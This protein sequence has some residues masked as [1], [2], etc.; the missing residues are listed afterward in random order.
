M[1]ALIAAEVLAALDGRPAKVLPPELQ[2]WVASRQREAIP[3][4]LRSGARAAVERV[5]EDSELSEL[6]ARSNEVAGLAIPEE[7]PEEHARCRAA[8]DAFVDA[9][10]GLVREA[11]AHR[12]QSIEDLAQT[13][14]VD[15]AHCWPGA[16]IEA[17]A[18]KHARECRQLA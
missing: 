6:W 11:E 3:D 15:I 14:D 13:G 1:Q 9:L 4:A 8:A 18:I 17:D 10:E 5:K 2:D 16:A 7:V 12:R